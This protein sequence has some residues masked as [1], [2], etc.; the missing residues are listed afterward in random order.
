[1]LL[2]LTRLQHFLGLSLEVLGLLLVP[3][4]L[5][6]VVLDHLVFVLSLCLYFMVALLLL[7]EYQSLLL[8][9]LLV[10]LPL[11]LGY[12]FVMLR[13]QLAIQSAHLLGTVTMQL[14]LALSKV[15]SD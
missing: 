11:K 7:R 15:R 6:L 9:D 3:L 12:L 2:D 14:H 4:L 1:M 8:L 13:L 10:Q 5:F